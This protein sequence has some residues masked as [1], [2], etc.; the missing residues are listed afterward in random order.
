VILNSC[1]VDCICM[2]EVEDQ[3][4]LLV[5]MIMK[6]QFQYR[7][8]VSLDYLSSCFV[9]EGSD[10]WGWKG[11]RKA[12]AFPTIHFCSH[13]SS[14]LHPLLSLY[15]PVYA[16]TS[17]LVSLRLISLVGCCAHLTKFPFMCSG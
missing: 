12:S 5:N 7:R 17:F 6:L 4:W 11:F 9:K 1:G 8:A 15:N 10:P 16:L 2:A 13:E 3:R 14:P